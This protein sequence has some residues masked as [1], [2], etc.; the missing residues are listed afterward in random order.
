MGII[1]EE[2]SF[3]VHMHTML[4]NCTLHISAT[5]SSFLMGASSATIGTKLWD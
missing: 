3:S 2:L 4:L 1:G 5:S